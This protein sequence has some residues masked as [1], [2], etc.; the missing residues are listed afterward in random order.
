VVYDHLNPVTLLP[1]KIIKIRR[2]EKVTKR[3]L[4]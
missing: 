3:T 4:K 1:H 2:K